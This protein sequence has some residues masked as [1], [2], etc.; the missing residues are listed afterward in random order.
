MCSSA[1]RG[2]GGLG[3]MRTNDPSLL[4]SIGVLCLASGLFCV[5]LTLSVMG[6]AYPYEARIFGWLPQWFVLLNLLLGPCLM[7]VTAGPWRIASSTRFFCAALML[8]SIFILEISFKRYLIA[9]CLV[10]TVLVIEAYWLIP[11]LNARNRRQ[12]ITTHH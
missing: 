6:L 2:K 12:R 7:A 4:A 8:C 9:S 5:W 1:W 11:K 10:L 3:L